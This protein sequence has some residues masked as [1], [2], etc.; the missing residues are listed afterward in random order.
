MNGET[1]VLCGKVFKF[2][3][4]PLWHSRASFLSSCS[5]GMSCLMFLLSL[6]PSPVLRV[7]GSDLILRTFP[8]GKLH[9]SPTHGC[10]L[11]VVVGVYTQMDC[12]EIQRLVNSILFSCP[13][14]LR[15]AF[16]L[17]NS[18]VSI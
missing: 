14:K 16:L 4:S 18:L 17:P 10:L 8:V 9:H 1:T 5:S 6:L 13:G 15:P 2:P 7:D 3:W 11:E 12:K